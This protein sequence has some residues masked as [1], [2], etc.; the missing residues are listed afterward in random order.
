[1][2][3]VGEVLVATGEADSAVEAMVVGGALGIPGA[4]LI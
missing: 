1:M 4:T 2:P 3:S